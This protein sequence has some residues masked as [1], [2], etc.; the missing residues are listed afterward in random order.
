MQET[1]LV[2]V[3]KIEYSYLFTSTAITLSLVVLIMP[4]FVGWWELGRSVT[5]NP[6]ETAKAFEAPLLSGPGSNAPLK[7]LISDAGRHRIKYGD[8]SVIEEKTNGLKVVRRQLV[9]REGFEVTTP[10][11]GFVYE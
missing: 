8:V 3:Y 6:I 9:F 7:E 1:R 10:K 2:N 11:N 5:L 4:T